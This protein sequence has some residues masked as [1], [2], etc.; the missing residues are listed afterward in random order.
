MTTAMTTAMTTTARQSDDRSRCVAQ[1]GENQGRLLCFLAAGRE[2]AV[3]MEHVQRIISRKPLIT[4]PDTVPGL[5]GLTSHQDQSLA[6]FELDGLLGRSAADAA[7]SPD[8]PQD[9]RYILILEHGATRL[10]LA[11]HAPRDILAAEAAAPGQTEDDAEESEIAGVLRLDNGRRIVFVLRLS[12]LVGSDARNHADFAAQAAGSGEHS[13]DHASECG[14][15]TEDPSDD[16]RHVCFELAGTLFAAPMNRVR[17]V[18]RLGQITPV[19]Q[20]RPYYAGLINLRGEIMPALDLR[21]RL[22]LPQAQVTEE[23][24]ILVVGGRNKHGLIVD[25]I[26]DPVDL[27]QTALEPLP[28]ACRDNPAKGFVHAVAKLNQRNRA[29]HLNQGKP[30]LLLDLDAVTRKTDE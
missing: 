2:Y 3:S 9:W 29:D 1:K 16:R 8:D 14:P 27:D 28:D 5:L 12:R 13:P 26:A 4:P 23:S 25:R 10:G 30:I 22:G 7:P 17:E 15:K 24:R 19:P 20:A 18:T 21:L 6:V 11:I